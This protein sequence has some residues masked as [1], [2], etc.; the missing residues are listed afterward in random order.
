[1][2]YQLTSVQMSTIKTM[3]EKAS[4]EYVKVRNPHTL[5]RGTVRITIVENNMEVSDQKLKTEL[6]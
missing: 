2:K 5:L 4:G 1:M 6:L 3:K